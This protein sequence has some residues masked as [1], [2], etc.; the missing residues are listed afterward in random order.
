MSSRGRGRIGPQV[1][2]VED[3]RVD[4]ILRTLKGVI[5]LMG[6]QTD[7]RNATAATNA[8]TTIA[9]TNRNDENCWYNEN[10]GNQDQG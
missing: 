7:E 3:S 10:V 9:A 5:I 4:G 8:K 6:G 2:I 1:R